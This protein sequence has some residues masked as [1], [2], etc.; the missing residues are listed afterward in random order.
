MLTLLHVYYNSTIE[1]QPISLEVAVNKMRYIIFFIRSYQRYQQYKGSL[2]M[3]TFFIIDDHNGRYS[4]NY[5]FYTLW[6][7]L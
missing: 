4:L 1:V 3:V 7:R 5:L 6:S 2:I